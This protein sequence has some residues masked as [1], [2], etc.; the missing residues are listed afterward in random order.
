MRPSSST[1]AEKE[2]GKDGSLNLLQRAK[3][4]ATVDSL[5][6]SRSGSQGPNWIKANCVITPSGPF[7]RHAEA[8]SPVCPCRLRGTSKARPPGDPQRGATRSTSGAERTSCVPQGPA[9]TKHSPSMFVFAAAL[10]CLSVVFEGIRGA[11]YEGDIAIDDVSVTKGRCKA[12]DSGSDRV[13][14]N[15]SRV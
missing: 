5:V 4:I 1:E 12:D 14:T 15:K 10:G 13:Q 9:H 6:W 8:P 11:G 2:R 7:Q 3:S